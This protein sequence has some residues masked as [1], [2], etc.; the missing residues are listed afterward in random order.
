MTAKF[1]VAQRN[2]V[3]VLATIR[4]IAASCTPAVHLIGNLRCDDLVR[5][6]DELIPLDEDMPG[7]TPN[8]DMLALYSSIY[9]YKIVQNGAPAA[10]IL[11]NLMFCATRWEKDAVIIGPLRADEVTSAVFSA[12]GGKDPQKLDIGPEPDIPA[13]DNEGSVSP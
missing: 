11:A 10:Q 13:P 2:T 5:A 12:L 3:M 8:I 4:A 1:N 9:S 7:K 6:I